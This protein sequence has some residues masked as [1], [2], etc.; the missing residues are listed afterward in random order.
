MEIH[1]AAWVHPATNQELL[2]PLKPDL[3]RTPLPAD[4]RHLDIYL[5]SEP[6]YLPRAASLFW[7]GKRGDGKRETRSRGVWGREK[8]RNKSPVF[9]GICRYG[10]FLHLIM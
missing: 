5:H 1:R 6:V 2:I 8:E 4:K 7:G 3:P 9:T 10:Y